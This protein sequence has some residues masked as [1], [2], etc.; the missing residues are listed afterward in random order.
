MQPSLVYTYNTGYAEHRW[1]LSYNTYLFVA[2]D[3][4]KSLESKWIELHQ[5]TKQVKTALKNLFWLKFITRDVVNK[6]L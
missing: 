4:V 5:F 2:D 6:M 3:L 1:P